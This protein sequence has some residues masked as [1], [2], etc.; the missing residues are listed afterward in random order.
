MKRLLSVAVIASVSGGTAA[1][2]G[3]QPATRAAGCPQAVS[4]AH[5]LGTLAFLRD[6]KLDV[7]D[8]RTCKTRALA[9]VP[10]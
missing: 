9:R 1:A 2:L 7:I 8:L 3:E 10:G 4:G 5:D 6:G